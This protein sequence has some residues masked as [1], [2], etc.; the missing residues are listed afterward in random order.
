MSVTFFRAPT[1]IY[2]QNPD[3]DNAISV[4]KLGAGNRSAG[5][6]RY[7]YPKGITIYQLALGWT[8]LRDS[9]KRDLLS[10]FDTTTQGPQLG[11]TYRDQR[12]YTW[13]AYFVDEKLEFR[14][15]ADERRGVAGTFASGGVNYPTTDRYRGVW[16]VDVRLEVASIATTTT[17]P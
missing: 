15:V 14:E 12:G 16:A 9:E 2:L 7:W 13:N 17:T 1:T 3:L 4:E 10:F 8:E 5:G 11:F 6:T